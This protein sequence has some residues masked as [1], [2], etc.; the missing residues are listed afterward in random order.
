MNDEAGALQATAHGKKP[1]RH[2]DAAVFFENLRPDDDVGDVGFVFE[3]HEHDPFGG[4]RPLPHQHQA[5]DGDP[6]PI[7][8]PLAGEDREG[9]VAQSCVA[10]GAERAE[11]IAE[12][13]H[14]M[15]LERQ[16]GRHV[17]LDDLLAERH[18]RK[19]DGLFGE[20]FVA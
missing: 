11:A 17:I 10:D 9:V 6:L 7:P 14:W 2:Y 4:S 8:S 1:R 20:K 15:V 5:G 19:R 13:T 12:K 16:S 18:G 3:G